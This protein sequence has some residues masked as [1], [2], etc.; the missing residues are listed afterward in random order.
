MRGRV[1]VMPRAVLKTAMLV[2]DGGRVRL[3]QDGLLTPTSGSLCVPM[4]SEVAKVQQD[5]LRYILKMANHTGHVFQSSQF[6]TW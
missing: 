4:C 6:A 3:V 5:R 1:T 2:L